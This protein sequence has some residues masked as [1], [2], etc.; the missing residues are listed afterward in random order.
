MCSVVQKMQQLAFNG[1]YKNEFMILA[2]AIVVVVLT[3][4]VIAKERKEIKTFAK[5]GWHLAAFCGVMNGIVNL[6]VMILS[7]RMPVSLMFP[8]ISAGG[9]VITYLV[10]K[11]FYKE[12]LTQRQFIG[13]IIG[14]ISVVF[15]NI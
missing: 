8:L 14:I 4:F 10:S 9:I 1:A 15:L 5:V 13:F 12:K 7:G 11:F 2:L 6:F 3:G